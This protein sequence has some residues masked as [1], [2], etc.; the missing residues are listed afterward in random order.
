MDIQ[1]TTNIQYELTYKKNT[2]SK[3]IIPNKMTALPKMDYLRK[4]T[5]GDFH[6]RKNTV[7][8]ASLNCFFIYSL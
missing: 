5:V 7:A 4:T 8:I 1:D 6:P 3:Q 2:I